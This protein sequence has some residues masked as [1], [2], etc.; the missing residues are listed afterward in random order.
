MDARRKLPCPPWSAIEEAACASRD[1]HDIKLA[2][3]CRREE[4]AYGE[5]LYR[6]AAARRL[7]LV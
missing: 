2:F 6:L 3:V 5:P 4:L 7:K 1:E